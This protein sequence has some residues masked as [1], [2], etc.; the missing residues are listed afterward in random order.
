[1][2]LRNR[3]SSLSSN[4]GQQIIGLGGRELA[5]GGTEGVAC[6]VYKVAL[7]HADILGGLDKVGDS[8]IR[9]TIRLCGTVCMTVAV[10]RMPV[11]TGMP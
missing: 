3:G 4:H 10:A 1:M 5:E 8:G 7:W 11:G 6:Q 2:S 9:D